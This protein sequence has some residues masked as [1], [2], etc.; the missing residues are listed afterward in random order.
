MSSR[1]ETLKES[2]VWSLVC[3]ICI[4]NLVF[5]YT[6]G[7]FN[8]CTDNVSA[9][10]SWGSKEASY[11]SLFS[12][13]IAIGQALGC[14]AS[15]PLM[16]NYGRRKASIFVDIC[17]IIGS[18]LIILP[19]TVTFGIGR[20]ITGFAT[21]VMATV[22]PIYTNEVTP[23]S[24]NPRVGPLVVISASVGLMLSYA[25]GLM[26]PTEN[27]A[28]NPLNNLWIF[29]FL[30][31]AALSAY[32]LYYFVFIMKLDTPQFYMLK[33]MHNEAQSALGITHDN[34]SIVYGL[35]RVNSDVSGKT[36]SGMK[37]S[38]TGMICKKKF[39]K[40]TRVAISM[41]FILQLCGP[42][43]ILFYSTNIF[44]QLGGGLFESRLITFVMGI[45]N[46]ISCT[47][48][49]WLLKY[50][51]RKALLV[52]GEIFIVIDLVLLGIFS[53]YVD[54]GGIVMAGFLI[55]YFIPYG[56]ALAGVFWVYNSEIL[57]DQLFSL[58]AI[59]NFVISIPV[60]IIFPSA[61]ES[62][63]IANCF[64]FFGICTAF[65]TIYSIFELVET[66][67]KDKE[68]ILIEMKVIDIRTTPQ[69]FSREVD[70]SQE[71]NGFNENDEDKVNDDD[72][73]NENCPED[74]SLDNLIP[75]EDNIPS[76]KK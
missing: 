2:K 8:T 66:K 71:L 39:R 12:T 9:Y 17:F 51:G 65:S 74:K 26:L 10:F 31:P 62:F 29:M 25:F 32:Q 73:A 16:N 15:A 41:G 53:G 46:V 72:I 63:G 23:V 40:M 64:L 38:L 58:L 5:L 47:C 57:N 7:V 1:E 22:S 33:N 67:D 35:R 42:T 37:V 59:V 4:G 27:F 6:L 68:T 11:I 49:I 13:F 48:A 44:S 28:E 20:L 76:T 70:S 69:N 56:Y 19:S 50:F 3:H 75:S 18:I 24:M 21:G 34:N 60:S 52:S 43:A 14:I 54:A 36:I 45:I 55:G 61:V 30:F